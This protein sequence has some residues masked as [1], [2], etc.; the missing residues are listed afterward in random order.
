M[1]DHNDA[2]NPIHAKNLHYPGKNL[3]IACESKRGNKLVLYV[4]RGFNRQI[5]RN[6]HTLRIVGVMPCQVFS[7]RGQAKNLD[8]PGEPLMI[9]RGSTRND[10]LSCNMSARFI[11]R[12]MR[13]IH[14]VS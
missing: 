9:A 7:P 12:I 8:Y 3:M 1:L 2:T 14:T 4:R 5:K 11:I 13:Y 10:E 6:T